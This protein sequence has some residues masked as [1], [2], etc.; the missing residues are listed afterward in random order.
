[1]TL[2]IL[3]QALRIVLLPR[4][5]VFWQ[6]KR[7][8]NSIG[9][10]TSV[11][12]LVPHDEVLPIYETSFHHKII[13]SVFPRAAFKIVIYVSPLMGNTIFTFASSSVI[14]GLPFRGQDWGFQ[15]FNWSDQ[16]LFFSFLFFI[17]FSSL[18]LHH[19]ILP[20]RQN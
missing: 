4:C 14:F 20:L 3:Y 1:M 18:S 9:H 17:F 8:P 13:G 12:V 19:F 7:F 2:E 6:K 5:H 15:R 10:Q 16:L 11:T